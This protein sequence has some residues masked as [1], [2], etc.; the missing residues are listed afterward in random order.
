[1]TD[2]STPA[3]LRYKN[4]LEALAWIKWLE[5]TEQHHISH[6]GNCGNCEPMVAGHRVDGLWGT[7][8]Y[9]YQGTLY[10]TC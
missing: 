1:M 5:K 7:T 10:H 8:V 3:A 6:A 4:S 9:E 2:R